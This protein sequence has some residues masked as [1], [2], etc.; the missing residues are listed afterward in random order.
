MEAAGQSYQNPMGVFD[1]LNHK[2]SSLFQFNHD[3]PNSGGGL[4]VIGS[5]FKKRNKRD[6][7][8]IRNFNTIELSPMLNE[9]YK[10][11]KRANPLQKKKILIRT[12]RNLDISCDWEPPSKKLHKAVMKEYYQ[13]KHQE[14]AQIERTESQQ[15]R[16]K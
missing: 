9:M 10:G 15:M 14:Q 3:D 16:E 4:P 11:N 12:Q 6:K 13:N 8:P 2:E 7:K 1:P 5:Q